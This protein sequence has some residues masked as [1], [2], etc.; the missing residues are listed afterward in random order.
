[1]GADAIKPGRGYYGLAGAI[2][3]A[4]IA[5]FV[6]V[7]WKGISS[8]PSRLQQVTAP[9]SAELTLAKPGDYTIFYEYQSV[10]GNRVY[11]TGEHVPGLECTLI[12]KSSGSP[13]PVSRS[14]VDSSYSLGGRAGKSVFGFHIDQPGVYEIK[15]SYGQGQEG[16]EI[17]LA[18][19]Q[20]VGMAIVTGVLGGLAALFGSMA[21]SILIAVV[22]AVKRHNAAKRLR[23]AGGPPPPIE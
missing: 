23:T 5:L 9:G 12:S 18:V 13:V 15:S 22:T 6:I 17:V 16:E 3:V 11:S 19:G 1:M 8:I 14:T 7:L 2:L 10:I 21:L 4:G 20:G